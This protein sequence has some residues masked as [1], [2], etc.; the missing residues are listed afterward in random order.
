MLKTVKQNDGCAIEPRS[1]ANSETS[2]IH[3][4]FVFP[5][6]TYPPKI[7]INLHEFTN[8]TKNTEVYK[9]V[10]KSGLI[11]GGFRMSKPVQKFYK[12]EN[13]I[14]EYKKDLKI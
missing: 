10:Q 13:V 14:F 11:L 9:P 6:G 1:C 4:G 12:L 8:F 7:Y 5:L 2:P 3:R